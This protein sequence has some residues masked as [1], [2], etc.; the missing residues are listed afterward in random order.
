MTV[1]AW[2]HRHVSRRF[3]PRLPP[4]PVMP[5][6]LLITNMHRIWQNFPTAPHPDGRILWIMYLW[7]S[8]WVR[9]IRQT[10]VSCVLCLPFAVVRTL[11]DVTR[12]IITGRFLRRQI[13]ASLSAWWER[14]MQSVP[15]G[16]RSAD[17]PVHMPK[18]TVRWLRWMRLQTEFMKRF[19]CLKVL[20]QSFR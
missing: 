17:S 8:E 14:Q 19:S 12:I 4:G 11:Q 18:R 3:S 10:E 5:I 7:V 20:S 6:S 15:D 2:I 13:R 9:V 1:E 16:P